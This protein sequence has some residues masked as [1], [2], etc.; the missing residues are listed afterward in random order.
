M[1]MIVG[2]ASSHTKRGKSMYVTRQQSKL[3][4]NVGELL[5]SYKSGNLQGI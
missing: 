5:Y 4:V 3:L 2:A 1:D